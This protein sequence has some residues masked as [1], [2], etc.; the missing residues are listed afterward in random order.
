[1]HCSSWQCSSAHFQNWLI[2]SWCVRHSKHHLQLLARDGGHTYLQYCCTLY[3]HTVNTFLRH[4]LCQLQANR[5]AIL[6]R[7]D[8]DRPI[9]F[10]A[11]QH[12]SYQVPQRVQQTPKQPCSV[13]GTNLHLATSLSAAV[14]AATH[15]T[16][17]SHRNCSTSCSLLLT[18]AE[19]CECTGGTNTGTV[20]A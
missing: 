18:P 6:H 5:R 17:K 3:H 2:P 15:N 10:T 12:P 11:V 8:V 1:V 19:W 4:T 7:G 20:P 14:D 16:P 13:R 9:A